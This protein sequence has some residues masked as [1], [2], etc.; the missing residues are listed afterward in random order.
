MFPFCAYSGNVHLGT[1]R[2]YRLAVDPLNAPFQR[3]VARV[4]C[5][6]WVEPEGFDLLLKVDQ[7]RYCEII[8]LESRDNAIKTM[9]AWARYGP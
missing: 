7:H 9:I 2:N 1:S 6:K 3:P 8:E 4:R 5:V